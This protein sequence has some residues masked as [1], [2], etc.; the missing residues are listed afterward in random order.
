[1]QQS[2]G[3]CFVAGFGTTQWQGISSEILRSINVNIYSDQIC[4]NSY[5]QYNRN[6]EFCAGKKLSKKLKNIHRKYF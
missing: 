4:K 1:M 6:V 2:A 5:S 3:K